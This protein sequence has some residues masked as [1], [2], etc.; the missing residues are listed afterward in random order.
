MAVRAPVRTAA[1][2]ATP[3][4]IPFKRDDC[5]SLLAVFSFLIREL[6]S[7]RFS[8]W[9]LYCACAGVCVCVLSECRCLFLA[10]VFKTSAVLARCLPGATVFPAL[11]SISRFEAFPVVLLALSRA[12]L[13]SL[14]H[15]CT[16]EA[17][18]GL[19]KPQKLVSRLRLERGISGIK[20]D[21]DLA[22]S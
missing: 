18:C 8:A 2:V 22:S 15:E 17:L 21:F 1:S 9:L 3:F 7:C 6:S 11:A 20:L 14:R 13:P 12:L 10:S 16:V 4:I 5:Q 19:S